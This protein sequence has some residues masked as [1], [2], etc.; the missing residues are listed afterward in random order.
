MFGRSTLA[1]PARAAE[2]AAWLAALKRNRR[3]IHRAVNGVLERQGVHDDLSKV[4]T[5]TLIAV[6]EEDVATP[7]AKAERLHAGI[8]G[9]RLERIPRA[10]HTSTLEQPAHVTRLL[11]DFFSG[12]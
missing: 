10:G 5:P 7:P 3:S 12:A 1:D 8:A 2:R 6:G 9:S 11:R 4:R